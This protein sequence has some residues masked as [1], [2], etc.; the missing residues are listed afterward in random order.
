MKWGLQRFT[1]FK[2]FE[3]IPLII[4]NLA[5]EWV[6]TKFVLLACKLRPFSGM[7][8]T[9]MEQC[10]LPLAKMDACAWHKNHGCMVY[11]IKIK[12]LN[13]NI[14]M[15]SGCNYDFLVGMA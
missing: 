11:K 4:R 12:L 9:C 15:V 8:F 1:H 14:L 6:Y 3:S 5:K 7:V 13:I 10:C 2:F